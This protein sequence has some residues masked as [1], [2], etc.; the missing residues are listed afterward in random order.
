MLI[1]SDQDSSDQ[2]IQVVPDESKH[3]PTENVSESDTAES[4][5]KLMILK[6]TTDPAGALIAID[7][8]VQGQ[9]P[10]TVQ[11]KQGK[12]VITFRKKG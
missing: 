2:K 1:A 10:L 9:S 5:R 7:D 6:I 11:L 8:S 12:H 4:I 3:P